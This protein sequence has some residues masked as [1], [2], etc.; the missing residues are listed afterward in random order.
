MVQWWACT[1]SPFQSTGSKR[2]LRDVT[3]WQL[4]HD[5]GLTT[6]RSPRRSSKATWAPPNIEMKYCVTSSCPFGQA[7]PAKNFI[8]VGDAT[9][10]R[11]RVVTAYKRANNIIA[12]DWPARS[13]DLNVIEHAWDTLQRAVHAR[14][15]AP[16][17]WLTSPL[18]SRRSGSTWTRTSWG[19]WCAAFQTGA[20]RWFEPGKT[21]PTTDTKDTIGCN[22]L[23]P[24]E[25]QMVFL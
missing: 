7:H 14:Q 2:W 10:H 22:N 9:S 24:S 20:V 4:H 3:G 11:A 19:G 8:L 6:K 25:R 18:L 5:M 13:L 21:T 16:T 1:S 23:F 17:A 15:L 12:E